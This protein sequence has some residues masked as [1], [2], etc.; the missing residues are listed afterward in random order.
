MKA[1]LASYHAA[2]RLLVPTLFGCVLANCMTI[3]APPKS[4]NVLN[5][6]VA[7]VKVGNVCGTAFRAFLDG[8]D[9]TSQFSPASPS[10]TTTQATFAG[11][12]SGT[13]SLTASAD[14]QH[15]FLFPYCSSANDTAT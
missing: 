11:L 3:T 12:S 14:V 7:K 4:G 10:S 1:P 15:W 13:H 6:V 5:P 2:R 9:V 8:L